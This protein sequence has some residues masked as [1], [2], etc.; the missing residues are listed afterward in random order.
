MEKPIEELIGAKLIDMEKSVC[1]YVT[2][3]FETETGEVY[4]TEIK[5]AT[6]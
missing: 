4:L 2:L 5:E 6:K 1:G 3:Y